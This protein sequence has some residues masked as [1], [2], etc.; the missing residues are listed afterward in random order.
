MGLQIAGSRLLALPA[1]RHIPVN[2][3]FRPSGLVEYPAS[4]STAAAR[5][6][7]PSPRRATPATHPGRS[8]SPS[9]DAGATTNWCS[10]STAACAFV[11][12][13]E[14][15]TA[16]LHDRALRVREV[17]LRLLVRLAIRPLVRPTALRVPV[18]TRLPTPRVVRRPL[19]CFQTRL[20]RPIAAERASRRCNSAGRSSPRTSAPKRVSSASR[21]RLAQQRVDLAFQALFLFLHPVVAHRL[22]RSRSHAPSSRRST[23]SPSAPDPTPAPDGPPPQQRWKS[24]RCR[25]RNSHS[26]RCCAPPAPGTQRPLP[27]SARPGATRTPRRVERGRTFT[28]IRGSYGALR[29]LPVQSVECPRSS[30]PPDR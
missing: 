14:P 26:V 5:R 11:A 23:A 15:L 27:A 19:L 7:F 28:I 13:L 1:R 12:L 4:A 16:R 8:R 22:A 10:A 9:D 20:R 30:R 21:V 2:G 25:R 18:L 17:A 6:T 29:R 24:S 3:L